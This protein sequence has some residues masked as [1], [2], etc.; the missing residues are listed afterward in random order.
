MT[1]LARLCSLDA[2]S[3]SNDVLAQWS[4][5]F[6]SPGTGLHLIILPRP[7]KGAGETQ[8]VFN[9]LVLEHVFKIILVALK[10]EY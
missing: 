6:L 10:N 9:L 7:T 3:A 5:T 4:P 1:L 8:I 2:L